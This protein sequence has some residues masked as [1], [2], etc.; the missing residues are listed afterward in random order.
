MRTIISILLALLV[1]SGVFLA[2]C[3][4]TGSSVY[5]IKATNLNQK[6][7]VYFNYGQYAEAIGSYKASLDIDFE[8][9]AT[10]YW[11]GR[12]Y[13]ETADPQSAIE[14]YRLAVRFTPAMEIAQ[15]AL[16]STLHDVGLLDESIIATKDFVKYRTGQA[17]DM[18]RVGQHF[19]SRQ[20]DHQAIIVLGRAQELEST[21]AAPSIV[22]AD[23]YQGKGD[24]EG[25]R[26][27]IMVA[28][29]ADPFYQGLAQRAGGL[30]I[31]IES[32]RPLPYPNLSAMEQELRRVDDK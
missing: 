30:G 21:N 4:S 3:S 13:Q 1:V 28:V 32:P 25:E 29:A 16:I 31:K 12:A 20:M 24:T 27:A 9:S 6:G 2:G 10:H 14:E 22:L 11:L 8:N 17:N 23:Y 26:E 7:Q 19:F 15:V 5:K 18:I